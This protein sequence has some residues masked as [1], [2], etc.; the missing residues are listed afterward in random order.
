MVWH[1][2][3]RNGR[4]VRAYI[5]RVASGFRAEPVCGGFPEFDRLMRGMFSGM[6]GTTVDDP[7]GDGPWRS[8][9]AEAARITGSDF[10][11]GQ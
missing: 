2:R 10:L 11:Y 7:P 3:N 1:C 5:E 8:M 6:R 9:N 4:A